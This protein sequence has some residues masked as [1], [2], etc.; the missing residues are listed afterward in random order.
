[1]KITAGNVCAAG[2]V[3]AVVW[4]AHSVAAAPA[5]P[6]LASAIS[7]VQ[8]VAVAAYIEAAAAAPPGCKITPSL[9]A[10]I[11]AVESGHGTFG[12]SQPDPATGKV[13]PPI[14]GPRLDGIEFAEIRD[15]DDGQLDGDPIYDR[16]VGPMQFI[17][18]TWAHYADPSDDPQN[19]F[20]AAKN[21]GR[22][23]CAV[24]EAEGRP[25][26]DPAVERAAILSYNYSDDYVRTVQQFKADF[27][28]LGLSQV[29]EPGRGYG[30]ITPGAVAAKLGEEGRRRWQQLGDAI[31]R[32]DANRV[33]PVFDAADPVARLV[34]NTLDS[35]PGDAVIRDNAA[36][37]APGGG[38]ATVAGIT[39]DTSL[40]APLQQL[41][42]DAA[43][44]RDHPHRFRLAV[45]RRTDR[46]APPE[47]RH[48][49]LRDVRDAVRPVQPPDRHPRHLAARERPRDRL[50]GRQRRVA[51]LRVPRVPVAP[52]ACR[53]VRPPQPAIRA[54]AL[55]HHRQLT[56]EPRN[57]PA[58][59]H[60]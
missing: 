11:G 1:M 36:T 4:A 37:A 35:T 39:V 17:P 43:A 47:L 19:L 20:D 22:L 56:V 7:G 26:T 15:T 57:L 2:A 46:A 10:A 23:L 12:D 48:Q 30:E 33:R 29:G 50:P 59:A 41:L 21:T 27:D 24:A 9:I 14:R 54:V 49:R 40:A 34:W 6:V 5:S 18:S 31:D 42:D 51:Q 60:G 58:T 32:T 16:A 8:P 45:P 3:A 13:N 28:Q 55:V 53:P 52:A 25:V 44:R 38:L